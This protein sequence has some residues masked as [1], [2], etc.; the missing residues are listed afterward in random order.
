MTQDL[1]GAESTVGSVGNHM[2][3]QVTTFHESKKP[4]L[5]LPCLL[6]QQ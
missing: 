5:S 1:L 2:L 6:A 4:L 3:L